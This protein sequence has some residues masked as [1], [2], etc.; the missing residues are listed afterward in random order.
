MSRD[1][2]LKRLKALLNEHVSELNDH[3][4][5]DDENDPFVLLPGSASVEASPGPNMGSKPSS[6]DNN[7]NSGGH[8]QAAR[9]LH[10]GLSAKRTGTSA[11]AG[12]ESSGTRPI[13]ELPSLP[14]KKL[15]R[16]NTD[17]FRRPQGPPPVPT[18]ATLSSQRPTPRVGW[19]DARSPATLADTHT[20]LSA[21]QARLGATREAPQLMIPAALPP[22][23]MGRPIPAALLHADSAATKPT[24]KGSGIQ[25]AAAPSSSAPQAHATA[26]T[27]NMTSSG[28]VPA[29][30]G[31]S[32]SRC[33]VCG[34]PG[35]FDCSRCEAEIYCSA[36]CQLKAWPLHAPHCN[37]EFN[38]TATHQDADG[39]HNEHDEEQSTTALPAV[40]SKLKPF[41]SQP[42]NASAS[43]PAAAAATKA[44]ASKEP[45]ASNLPV[46]GPPAAES[47]EPEAAAAS[48]STAQC[49]ADVRP[50][51]AVDDTEADPFQGLLGAVNSEMPLSTSSS[52]R[53]STA[54]LRRTVIDSSDSEDEEGVPTK[55]RKRRKDASSWL[56]TS[57]AGDK[58]PSVPAFLQ[59]S[60]EAI[61]E[62]VIVTDL[63][64]GT[65]RYFGPVAFAPD[66]GD[67]CGIALDEPFGKNDG[68]VRG[69]R[70][71]SCDKNHGH[72][73]SAR[74]QSCAL[75]RRP[76]RRAV[77]AWSAA[78]SA[79]DSESSTDKSTM[80]G[81]IEV[82]PFGADADTINDGGDRSSSGGATDLGLPALKSTIVAVRPLDAASQAP[83]PGHLLASNLSSTTP[84]RQTTKKH[85]VSNRSRRRVADMS[86]DNNTSITDGKSSDEEL[87]DDDNVQEGE[88]DDIEVAADS[89]TA[90]VVSEG[91]DA[92]VYSLPTLLKGPS[93]SAIAQGV[94]ALHHAANVGNL[95][96]IKDL[97]KAGK[98]DV[99]S[100]DNYGRTPLMHAVHRQHLHCAELLIRN[101]AN[102]NAQANDGSSALHEAA[103]RCSAGV[104][105]LLLD[106]GGDAH[107]RDNNGRQPVHWSTDNMTTKCM[108]LLLKKHNISVNTVD[109]ANMTPIMWA[110][111]HDSPSHIRKLLKAGAEL[112]EKDVDGKTAMDWAVHVENTDCLELLMDYN[113]TFYK[114]VKGR[115]VLH[116]AAERGALNAA[117]LILK[118]RPDS[119]EDM[120]KSG[121]TPLFWA[122]A[123]DRPETVLL[124]L[125]EG[126]DPD[127]CDR[128]GRTALDYAMAKGHAAC[129]DAFKVNQDPAARVLGPLAT[130]PFS[131][132]RKRPASASM[133][134]STGFNANKAAA[135]PPATP[136]G[137]AADAPLHF[138]KA[139]AQ[140]VTQGMAWALQQPSNLDPTLHLD[141]VA[142]VMTKGGRRLFKV[143]DS[144]RGRAALRVFRLAVNLQASTAQLL[145]SR[146]SEDMASYTNMTSATIAS[147]SASAPDVLHGR[148]DLP[149]PLDCAFSIQ[150]LTKTIILIAESSEEKQYWCTALE[151]IST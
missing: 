107:I 20:R 61:G 120:D 23:A 59:P 56:S 138:S 78:M 67:W 27:A 113:A 116:T 126:A 127:V 30:P 25:V 74:S 100:M 132:P 80:S 16:P 125:L 91:D 150:T 18:M 71:F 44:P 37:S 2:S 57:F 144:G 17:P 64:H 45:P 136:S 87:Q 95:Q 40:L 9:A 102:V 108:T 3:D 85:F 146:S 68:K 135:A 38:R 60:A 104:L 97:L 13:E 96:G 84:T 89:S 77:S 29:D 7:N 99:N 93:R 119:I 21:L 51:G 121:R 112:Q 33:A 73:V 22:V 129:V 88:D 11:P 82:Q 54:V 58:P 14:S 117:R 111:V 140:L 149:A 90:A 143:G 145:W 131:A 128:D 105:A 65:L 31:D 32:M 26:T 83:L 48:S 1:E 139:V 50:P 86:G 72:F 46:L 101:G 43:P 53:P 133:A 8:T 19:G 92:S 76:D 123:C 70:Y 15:V 34:G 47:P 147:Y 12:E 98:L 148:S 81:L 36:E 110:A 79:L 41:S 24:A 4:D 103:Y 42:P 124:L 52:A 66:T 94:N 142:A 141:S 134:S 114:D 10:E 39:D 49:D 62:R 106:N 130:D 75:L 5:V 115:T 63:G 69:K 109:D 118:L 137:G 35:N 6:S 28:S 151:A 122:A 55:Q